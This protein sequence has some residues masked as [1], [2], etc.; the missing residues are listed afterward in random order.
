M[1]FNF[2]YAQ[3][4]GT[5]KLIIIIIIKFRDRTNCSVRVTSDTPF[6][7]RPLQTLPIFTGNGRLR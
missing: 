7:S 4:D 1:F 2:V 5:N 3:R 6:G